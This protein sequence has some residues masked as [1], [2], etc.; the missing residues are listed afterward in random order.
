MKT[1]LCNEKL[2]NVNIY[3]SAELTGGDLKIT[4]QD[5]GRCCEEFFGDSDYEYF[6]TFD[7]ENTEKLF[8]LLLDE[9]ATNKL[10]MLKKNF[11]G[12]DCCIK[13]REFCQKHSIKYSFFC[14]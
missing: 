1:E 9:P 14:Y 7:A 4:G 11:N 5:I 8:N 10:A 12:P 2:P 6:Y 3:V 13:L